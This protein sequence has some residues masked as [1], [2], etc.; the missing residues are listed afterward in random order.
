LIRDEMRHI[1][2]LRAGTI[3]A[4]RWYYTSR[5]IGNGGGVPREEPCADLYA[6]PRDGTPSPWGIAR[7]AARLRRTVE[8]LYTFHAIRRALGRQFHGRELDPPF[9]PRF[10]VCVPGCC[11]A[12][13]SPNTF[14][15]YEEER[16]RLTELSDA[17]LWFGRVRQVSRQCVLE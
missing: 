2:I 1:K 12:I 13:T 8:H 14:S 11:A 17:L 16:E 4:R 9:R 5:G 3:P 6:A 10:V 7:A 15:N